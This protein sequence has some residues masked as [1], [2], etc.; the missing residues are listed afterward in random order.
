M[1][2][3]DWRQGGGVSSYRQAVSNAELV[4]RQVAQLLLLMVSLGAN[5]SKMH[6]VGFSLGAQVAGYVGYTLQKAGLQLGR[7]TG[8][9]KNEWSCNLEH[10]TPNFNQRIENISVFD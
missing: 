9:L 4:G 7:I 1:V 8:N 6:V 5:A 10:G 2:L 3:V